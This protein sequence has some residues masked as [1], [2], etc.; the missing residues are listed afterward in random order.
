M[1]ALPQFP[2]KLIILSAPSG[3]GKTTLAHA[4]AER[5]ASQGLR[6]AFSV[7]YTTRAPRTGEQDGVD[8]HFV[9]DAVFG[10]MV[11]RGEFLEHAGVFG[12]SYGTG[13]AATER[14]L[15]ENDWLILDIDWQG[16][17]Q[18]RECWPQVL[19]IFIEPPSM[20][21][22]RR[23]LQGRG[24]DDAAT[25]DSRM[26]QAESEM[27]HA[28]EFDLRIVNDDLQSALAALEAALKQAASVR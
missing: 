21:E 20:E 1:T 14:M 18:V 24:Q 11:E 28:D 10:A 13:R 23:R 4:L 12:R 15:A 8:Y 19:S 7:S 22:L 6:I 17:R 26:A 3:A 9:D 27:S 2:G 25:I 5:M 16:A